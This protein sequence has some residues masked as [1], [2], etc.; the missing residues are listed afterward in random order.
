MKR[1]TIYDIAKEAKVSPSMVSR[2]INNSGSVK[3]EK[4]EKILQIAQKYNYVPNILARSLTK[5]KSKTIGIILPDIS[6]PFFLQ[7]YR[8][9]EKRALEKGYNIILGNSFSKYEIESVYLRSLVEKQ[10][11][12]IIFLGG[13]IN[14]CKLKDKYI[15][16]MI[17]IKNKVPIAT[18]NS[19]YEEITTTNIITDEEK[20]FR[21]LMEFICKR[22]FKKVGIILGDQGVSSTES[23]K[24]YFLKYVD[25]YH[26]DTDEKWIIYSGFSIKAGEEGVKKLLKA[27]NLPEVLMCINDIVAIGAIR[28][29][30]LHG[31]KVP[32]NIKVTGF[33]DIELAQTFIPSL[34]TVNQNYSVIGK[35]LIDVLTIKEENKDKKV[36]VKTE[37]KVRESCS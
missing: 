24:E 18:V 17:A 19:I 35:L 11:D 13:R 3:K 14:D 7:I 9:A 20:G 1:V 6:N 15:E 36:V 27:D 37:V 2:V 30:Y 16:E 21:Q 22:G 34:T 26:L 31:L 8:E 29:L 5:K 10:V 33:D 25:E 28:E 32:E 12:G 4:A 23:K